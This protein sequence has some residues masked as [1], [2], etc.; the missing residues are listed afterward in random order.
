MDKR[1]ASDVCGSPDLLLHLGG[2]ALATLT[3]SSWT[4]WSEALSFP[5]ESQR[6][7]R[8]TCLSPL[9]ELRPNKTFPVGK[10]TFS[11]S[12]LAPPLTE[13]R[14]D[15]ELLDGWTS[16]VQELPLLRE[17]VTRT[18]SRRTAEGGALAYGDQAMGL[19]EQIV[20]KS[21][22]KAVEEAL[23]DMAGVLRQAVQKLVE[24]GKPFLPFGL[25]LK[26]EEGNQ[27]RVVSG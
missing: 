19:L 25:S 11:T 27:Y 16:G 10:T 22:L 7:S 26:H 6:L 23:E 14:R 12:R 5:S 8:E 18:R 21:Q 15:E 13:L 3:A 2:D 9:L 17:V 1:D 20:G 4:G 24:A